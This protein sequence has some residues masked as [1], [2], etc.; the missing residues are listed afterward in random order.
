MS[1]LLI[2]GV[3]TLKCVVHCIQCLTYTNSTD[4]TVKDSL[5]RKQLLA[6]ISAEAKSLCYST[7]LSL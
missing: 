4:S 5:L 1:L 7:Q 2:N 6:T 3:Y